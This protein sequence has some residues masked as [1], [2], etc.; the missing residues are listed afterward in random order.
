MKIKMLGAS[1]FVV[2]SFAAGYAAGP[3]HAET[4]TIKG[5]PHAD[6]IRGTAKHDVICAG[7][8]NDTIY[9]LGGN[10]TINGGDGADTIIGGNGNDT[11]NGNSGN[12]KLNGNPGNDTLNGGTGVDIDAGGDGVDMCLA[13]SGTEYDENS[14]Q[15]ICE[16]WGYHLTKSF[17]D[18]AEQFRLI[19]PEEVVERGFHAI[20]DGSWRHCLTNNCGDTTKNYC[21]VDPTGYVKS[22]IVW[23]GYGNGWADLA[24]TALHAG[25][26]CGLPV[27]WGYCD[28]NDNPNTYPNFSSDTWVIDAT[29][30]WAGEGSYLVAG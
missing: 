27:E 5:T 18:S 22:C 19:Y 26:E 4:C 29:D 12:D 16:R 11:E 25:A 3:V 15:P 9:G 8:G 14:G 21:M 20:D 13:R 10:D 23:N 17:A 1:V 24:M 7:A 6:T 28:Q 30:I 2:S